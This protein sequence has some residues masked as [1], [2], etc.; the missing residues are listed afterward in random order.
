MLVAGC[1]WWKQFGASIGAGGALWQ[2]P[3][4]SQPALEPTG[5]LPAPLHTLAG[6]PLCAASTNTHLPIP[7]YQYL[8]INT[9]LPIP[10]YQYLSVLYTP[11]F[12]FNP[13]PMLNSNCP[14]A[15]MKWICIATKVK[16]WLDHQTAPK[17]YC[18]PF[19]NPKT[20]TG[21]VIMLDSKI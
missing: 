18:S 14:F 1:W 10:I 9:H 20:T 6:L 7:L 8:S 15:P 4:L 21:L 12:A 19:Y 11:L 5:G 13:L 16:G 17:C 2:R 3:Y